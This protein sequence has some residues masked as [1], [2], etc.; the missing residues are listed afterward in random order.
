MS[1]FPKK[2][3]NKRSYRSLQELSTLVSLMNFVHPLPYE[4]S[5]IPLIQMPPVTVLRMYVSAPPNIH[6]MK[7]ASESFEA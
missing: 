2:K 3:Q 6:A 1:G 5:E 7:K 4:I